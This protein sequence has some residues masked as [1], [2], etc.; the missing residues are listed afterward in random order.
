MTIE[1]NEEEKLKDKT[2]HKQVCSTNQG[3]SAVDAFE[4][5]EDLVT[6]EKMTI[7][8]RKQE[9]VKGKENLQ[10]VETEDYKNG[11]K[12]DFLSHIIDVSK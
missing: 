11:H 12:L 7:K 9:K 2:N 4:M 10:E 3:G 8:P 5:Q 1:Q 6:Q